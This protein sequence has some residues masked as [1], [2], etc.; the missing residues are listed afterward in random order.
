MCCFSMF[1]CDK[2]LCLNLKFMQKT[3]SYK[4]EK[5]SFWDKG[6][7]RT[8]VLLHGFLGAKEVW[9]PVMAD[10]AKSYRVIAIDLPGHG[11]TPN[12]GYAHSMDTMAKCVKA[13]LDALKLKKYV[14]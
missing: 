9:Q 8:V 2:I 11:H 1:L 3:A 5:I 10:L 14:L 13:V 7:G 4:K 6:K 12:L